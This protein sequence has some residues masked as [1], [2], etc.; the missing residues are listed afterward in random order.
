MVKPTGTLKRTGGGG[1][2]AKRYP[3]RAQGSMRLTDR[4]V[5][6]L[7]WVARHGIVTTDQIARK[8]FPTPQG[9]SA[10]VQRVR[11][12]CTAGPPLLQRDYTHY[13]EPSVLRVT[14]HGARLADTGLG[15][16]RIVPAEVHHALAI[17]D[18]A[19]SL[20]AEHPAA[21][22][23]TERERRGERY[24]DKAAGRL[25]AT[26]RIADAVLVFPPGSRG[27]ERRVAVELDRSPRSE[28]DAADVIK[29][30]IAVRD[31][32]EVWWYVRPNRVDAIRR[33]TRRMKVDN[34]IEVRPW[35]GV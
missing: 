2:D 15:P 9:K 23:L 28:K 31:Y 16:A 33:L 8:F 21:S 1:P 24:R 5:D 20:L 32:T 17:V 11:K 30:Y 25:K 26:G 12:L 6:I 18:L 14:I 34:L 35:N 4:D 29:A 22:L 13:R 7:K 27:R 19:E 3:L 10:C